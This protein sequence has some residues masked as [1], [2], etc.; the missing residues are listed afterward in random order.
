MQ[1]TLQTLIN[2]IMQDINEQV[3]PIQKGRIIPPFQ[4]IDLDRDG[5]VH[6]LI[7]ASLDRLSVSDTIA[8][9]NFYEEEI[10]VVYH[11]IMRDS[12]LTNINIGVYLFI[13]DRIKQLV[14]N[15]GNEKEVF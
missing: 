9:F 15:I 13:R 2:E 12:E 1:R 7:E 8:L 5:K 6:K 14:E 3:I 11:D 10:R 4:L